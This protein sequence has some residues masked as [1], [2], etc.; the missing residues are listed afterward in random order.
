MSDQNDPVLLK[1][2]LQ[3]FDD[4]VEVGK[5]LCDGQASWVRLW[6]EGSPG[7]ALVPIGDD[8]MSLQLGV[9]IA[10]QWP[11]GSSRSAMEPE[12]DGRT[13]VGRTYLQEELRAVHREIL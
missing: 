1:V 8:E 9:E 13:P 4:D 11:F 6:I 7:A 5:V 3:V 12:H 10:E 2:P